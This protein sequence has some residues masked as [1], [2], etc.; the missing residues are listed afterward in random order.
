[1]WYCLF[2]KYNIYKYMGVNRD[3]WEIGMSMLGDVFLDII[4]MKRA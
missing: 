1:M 2:Y 3:I 4:F